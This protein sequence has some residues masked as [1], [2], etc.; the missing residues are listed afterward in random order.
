MGAKRKNQIQE[1]L[2]LIEFLEQEMQLLEAELK[3]N[4]SPVMENELKKRQQERQ[5]ILTNWG[6]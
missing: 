6:L 1:V 5:I 3:D 4:P 2:E